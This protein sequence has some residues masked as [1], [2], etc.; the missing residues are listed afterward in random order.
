MYRKDYLLHKRPQHDAQ[1]QREG[2]NDDQH[3]LNR[4]LPVH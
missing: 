2:R 4:P 1:A 3:G